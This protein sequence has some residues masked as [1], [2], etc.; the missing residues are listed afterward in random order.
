[1]P[2]AARTL[3]IALV[4]LGGLAAGFL[5]Y[6]GAPHRLSRPPL[7]PITSGTAGTDTAGAAGAAG[8]PDTGSS[9]SAGPEPE[10]PVGRPIP[11]IVPDL[12]LP[13]LAGQEKSLRGFLGRPLII[14]FWATWCAPC[15]REMP[16]LQQLR[17]AYHADRLEIVGI[18][19]DF[20]A[21]VADYVQRRA[22]D[23]PLLI[24]EDQ[25]LAAAEQFGMQTVLPFSVFAD[26]QG[27]IIAVKIGEL[28]R[29]EADYILGAM[30]AV[31]AGRLSLPEAHADIVRRL[32][33][34]AAERARAGVKDS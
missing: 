17:Q 28:H 15:R 7:A 21:A 25:G 16:L 3:A 23:Y 32:R 13:D 2:V 29:D 27:R 19:V 12:R 26:A 11:D 5:A 10:G 8:A 22:V 18:A 24:G 31:A 34:L 4:T 6:R 14:N 33:E 1:M 30:R 20:R 9:A